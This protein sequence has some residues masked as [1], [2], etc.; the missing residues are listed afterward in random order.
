[1]SVS[2]ERWQSDLLEREPKRGTIRQRLESAGPWTFWDW[3]IAA[4]LFLFVLGCLGV[5]IGDLTA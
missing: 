4:V 3:C 1:M 5:W 2:W